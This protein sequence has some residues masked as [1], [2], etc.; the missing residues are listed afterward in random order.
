MGDKPRVSGNP[1]P[2]DLLR[3]ARPRQWS[4]NILVFAAPGAAG[5]LT[6]PDRLARTLVMVAAFSITASGVYFLN[7]VND[8][9]DDR[10]HP[11]KKNRPIASG[12]V[13][14]RLGVAV[15]VGLVAVGLAVAATLGVDDFAVLGIYALLT[16]GYTLGM[17]QVPVIE[18]ACV[19]AGFVL[20]AIAG[21]IAAEVPVSQW[22]LIV[23]GAGSLFVV[24]AKRHAELLETCG[25]RSTAGDEK[26]TTRQSLTGYTLN[27]IRYVWMMASGV[28]ITAY[29]LWAFEEGAAH[30][31]PLWYQASIGPFVLAIMRYALIV[32]QG[33]AGEP[34]DVILSDPTLIV[35]GVA[36]A[37]AFGLGVFLGG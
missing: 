32:E 8:V 30:E 16:V 28:A 7:D 6:Q 13:S 14:I 5:V 22:F 1:I 20:R 21:A 18:L 12:T 25:E 10:R 35:L 4:K 2:R 9:E 15:G 11:T 19:A 24:A 17:K 37:S 23:T 34:E 27:Y 26:R 36:W 29:A 33:R 31:N 3:Q